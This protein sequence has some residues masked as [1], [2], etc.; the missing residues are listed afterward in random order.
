MASVNFS[1][2]EYGAVIGAAI[3]ALRRGDRQDA[4][5]LNEM[6]SKMNLALTRAAYP[7]VPGFA[8]V[9]RRKFRAPGP[10][11]E[12]LGVSPSESG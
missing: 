2:K 6:A 8:G 10:I 5:L 11:D 1:E 4:V 3:T 9:P 7:T 12:Q